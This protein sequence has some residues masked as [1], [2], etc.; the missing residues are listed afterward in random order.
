MRLV[1]HIKKKNESIS[2]NFFKPQTSEG[3]VI[4]K[5]LFQNPP[6]Q[7]FQHLP[8][9]ERNNKTEVK[10]MRIGYIIDTL[11]SVGI[12][13][14]VEEGEKMIKIYEGVIYRKRFEVNIF[15]TVIETIFLFALKYKD[16][17]NEVMQLL[18]T[19]LMNSLCASKYAKLLKNNTLVNWKSE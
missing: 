15:R 16:E 18:V 9:R 8:F 6:N 4:L 3:S 1:V 7:I 14:V 10:R 11:T 5:A 19:L 17:N 2:W 13:E 12:Q